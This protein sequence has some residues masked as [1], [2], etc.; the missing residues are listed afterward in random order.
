MIV[1]YCRGDCRICT[2]SIDYVF[3]SP[4]RSFTTH[5]EWLKKDFE[6]G[7]YTGVLK[8]L[9]SMSCQESS[10]LPIS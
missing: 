4:R 3:V 8:N 5:C 7:Q 1:S 6:R 9:Q 10:H 2:Y